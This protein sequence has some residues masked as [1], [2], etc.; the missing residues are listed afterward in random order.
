M[1]LDL[2]ALARTLQ[3]PVARRPAARRPARHVPGRVPTA[4]TGKV[5]LVV[6]GHGFLGSH[7][8]EALLARGEDRVHIFDAAPSRLFDEEI[9]RGTVVFHQGDVRDARAVEAACAGVSTVFH[10]AARVDYWSDLPFELDALHAVNVTGTENVIA[11]CRA[12]GV[13]QLLFTSSSSVVVSADILTRPVALA[14]ESAPCATAP[15]LCHYIRT[16][17]AAE[18]AVLAA[19]GRDGLR[20]AALRPGGMYGPRD[21]LLVPG[22]IAGFPGLGRTDNV[23]DFIYVE[24]VAHAFL[25][26]EQ[27]LAPGHVTCGRAYFVTNY[28][29]ACGSETYFAFNRRLAGQFGNRF[30]LAPAGVISAL[31]AAVEAAVRVS[32]GKVSA[33]L[34]DLG[35][36]RPSSVTLARATYYFTH[37]RAAADFG[38]APLYTVEEG[39]DRTAAHV[40][41]GGD[42]G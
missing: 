30:R 14:D 31:A 40:R 27:H 39:M 10:T 35:K 4:R 29:P 42:A 6:G 36:L 1:N 12:R 18:R 11:A 25:L 2:G 22:A 3:R 34:G 20:T 19:D 5:Y 32:G 9:R 33:H 17:V 24:N 37:R 7:L 41:L 28:D 38:Y 26:L 13:G 21:T 16:K 8:V 23:V 15:Y